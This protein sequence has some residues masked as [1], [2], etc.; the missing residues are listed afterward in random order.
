MESK[1]DAVISEKRLKSLF[2][3]KTLNSW[4]FFLL[5]STPP[6][7]D[8]LWNVPPGLYRTI[9]IMMC[10]VSLFNCWR[11]WLDANYLSLIN[12]ENN[13]SAGEA[14]CTIWQR[15]KLLALTLT[16]REKGA[17]KMCR[18]SLYWI[19]ALWMAWLPLLF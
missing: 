16:Q 2:V 1:C 4:R 17:I 15:E 7:V 8:C 9:I 19:I 12:E 13:A 11:L 6:L 3:V 10:G 5:L 18:T 14:L